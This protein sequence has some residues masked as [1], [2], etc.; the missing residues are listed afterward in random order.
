MTSYPPEWTQ[1]VIA[2]L[3]THSL[4]GADGRLLRLSDIA[5]TLGLPKVALV[6]ILNDLDPQVAALLQGADL[7]RHQ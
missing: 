5:V 6:S 1:K 4:Y 7:P 3:C 2:Y